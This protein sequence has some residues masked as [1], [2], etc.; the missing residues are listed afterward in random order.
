MIMLW[1]YITVYT[2]KGKKLISS[3]KHLVVETVEIVETP[4][5]PPCSNKSSD[6][7]SGWSLWEKLNSVHLMLIRSTS[8]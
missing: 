1:L 4:E 5:P 6:I 7:F 8:W 2:P 3:T